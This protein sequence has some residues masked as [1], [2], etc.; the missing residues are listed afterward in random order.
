MLLLET[1]MILFFKSICIIKF[2]AY[3]EKNFRKRIQKFTGKYYVDEIY[4]KVKGK[5]MYLY[6]AID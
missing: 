4:V 3:I 6:R 2:S 5:D 1:F